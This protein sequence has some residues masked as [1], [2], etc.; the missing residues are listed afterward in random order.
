[1]EW[2]TYNV[3]VGFPLY[4]LFLFGFAFYC[5]TNEISTTLST[6]YEGRYRCDCQATDPST[7]VGFGDDAMTCE[8]AWLY[9]IYTKGNVDQET[10]VITYDCAELTDKLRE[11]YNTTDVGVVIAEALEEYYQDTYNLTR[12]ESDYVA[13]CNQRKMDVQN[14]CTN[15]QNEIEYRYGLESSSDPIKNNMYYDV[16]CIP[17]D[18]AL[19]RYKQEVVASLCY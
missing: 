15:W 13:F 2:I 18:E 4:N 6:T 9:S 3:Q 10:G 14:A 17:P 8:I 19:V 12:S 5:Y 11:D 16:C 1:M 7:F